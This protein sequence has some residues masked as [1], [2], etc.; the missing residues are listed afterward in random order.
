MLQGEAMKQKG[1]TMLE[2][3]V[4]LPVGAVIVLVVV[5]SFFQITQGRI[6]IAQK[7]VAMADIDNAVHWLARDLVLAQ[8]TNLTDGAPPTDNMTL[9]WTDLTHWAQDEGSIDHSISYT[10]SGTELRRNYDG[11]VTIVGRYLTNVGFSID[12]RVFTITLTSCPD[13]PG[14]TVTKSFS[15]EMRTDLPP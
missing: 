8:T 9:S 7:S 11:G 6:D 14:S 3:L 5:S 1:F 13:L 2:L 10:L 4:A 12:E 15:T